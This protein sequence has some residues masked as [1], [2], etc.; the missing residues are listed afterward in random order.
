MALVKL[1]NNWL[2]PSSPFKPD[3][4]RVFS[5]VLY[6]KGTVEIPDNLVEFLPSN[7]VVIDMAPMAPE[8][9][10]PKEETLKDYDSYRPSLEAEIVVREGAAKE[11]E[12]IEKTGKKGK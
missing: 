4:M 2:A 5:G 11:A 6:K 8:P 10:M 1:R 7:A 9:V 12:K 3:H